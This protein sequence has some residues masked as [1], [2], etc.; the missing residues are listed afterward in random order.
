MENKGF[1]TYIRDLENTIIKATDDALKQGI[2]P[3]ILCLVLKS[4][5]Y[6]LERATDNVV[7]LEKEEIKK[8]QE[9]QEAQNEENKNN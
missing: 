7:L 2:Q 3:S 6:Q 9:E 4:A 8:Q 5:L 1:N